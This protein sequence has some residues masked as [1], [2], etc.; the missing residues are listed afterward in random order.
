MEE[1]KEGP[2]VDD[3]YAVTDGV[4]AAGQVD[5]D[6]C[7]VERVVGSK[8]GSFLLILPVLFIEFL[9]I[10]FTKSLMPGRLNAF[11]GER[12]YWVMGVS[13]TVKGALAF[14]ACPLFG[15]VSDV[16]GRCKCLFV[17]VIGTTMPCWILA[18]T[19][20]L[21]VY[22]V[23]WGLSG[24]FAATFTLTF[25]YVADVVP[26]KERAPA[27]GLALATLGL[28]FTIGP[29][30]GAF[31]ATQ[32]GEA[33]VFLVS[34]LLTLLDVAFIAFVLPETVEALPSSP[35][36]RKEDSSSAAANNVESAKQRTL[37]SAF[38]ATDT[39]SLFRGDPLL[40]KVAV[41][42]LLYYSGVWALVT[43]IVIYVV[44]VFGMT[45]VEVGW[46][47]G[48]YGLSTM[49]AEG[50]LVRIVVPALG[51]LGTMRLGLL[52]FAGQ[53]ACVA[54]AT[55]PR[56]IFASISFSLV[57]NLVYPAVSSYVSRL[58]PDK[59]IGEALGAINGV[60]ALTEGAG[61]LTFAAL[62][63]T[64]EQTSL[65][66]FPY[67]FCSVVAVAALGLTY[68][69]PDEDAYADFAD[70]AHFQRGSRD[71]VPLELVSLLDDCEDNSPTTQQKKSDDEYLDDDNPDDDAD[72]ES[73]DLSPGDDDSSNSS[74]S[75][76][77][78][79]TGQR[80]KNKKYTPS[81][82]RRFKK[83]FAAVAAYT[84]GLTTN[85]ATFSSSA[86]LPQGR[87]L[88]GQQQQSHLC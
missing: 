51:E 72:D 23:C 58:V 64:F 75:H 30:L 56:L 34:L 54:V 28:S 86:D 43:T 50:V 40:S 19:D 73:L 68:D 11:F 57:S 55:G 47:L 80:Q 16:L 1:R 71:K 13:E 18:F 78:R 17:T 33:R 42:V 76:R 4:E 24:F 37:S 21:W 49:I 60:K 53:C 6:Q 27:Y 65:P 83:S 81:R 48:T 12:V 52:A 3:F 15:R 22:V 77:R 32:F 25:A 41:V 2:F 14:A 59:Q 69:M 46:L 79:P 5:D 88:K 9:A 38:E 8:E 66:G 61:P 82:Y 84:P 62:M 63:S 74:E 26:A 31:A 35:S 10:A 67:L 87:P 29:P 85:P 39:L 7:S 70:K 44:R 36:R 45:T 20:D